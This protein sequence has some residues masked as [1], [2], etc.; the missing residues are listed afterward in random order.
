MKRVLACAFALCFA[1]PAWAATAASEVGGGF[2][3]GLGVIDSDFYALADASVF[4]RS[5][6]LQLGGHLPLRLMLTGDD[7]VRIR[8]QDWDEISDVTRLLRYLDWHP[9]DEVHLR[10]GEP[11]GVTLGHG[12]IVDHFYNATDLDHYKTSMRF[13]WQDP[14][15]GLE[16]FSNDMVRWEILAARA[17]F[18][19]LGGTTSWV[20]DL[21]VALTLAVDRAAPT[22]SSGGLDETNQPIVLRS[23]IS[24]YGVDADIPL[25]RGAQRQVLL[26]TDVVGMHHSPAFAEA[27]GQN[28]GGWHLGVRVQLPAIAPNTDLTVRLE[29]VYMGHGYVPGY[30]DN[31]YEV[32]RFEAQA[33]QNTDQRT[34]VAWA[35]QNNAPF[36]LRGQLD[37]VAERGLRLTVLAALLGDDGLSTQLWLATP[38]YAGMT[39]RGHWGQ[40][41]LQST[42]DM[43]A[44]AR[45]AA[46]A[47]LRYRIG[48]ALSVVMQAG[49]RWEAKDDGYAARREFIG[50]A[51]L[52]WKL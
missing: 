30:F 33:A 43:R 5:E 39:L 19:P 29:G 18:K 8:R 49:T 44:I 42:A 47:E 15:F 40:Q 48:A 22:G 16:V 28:T 6:S 21:Q 9:S 46:L 12:A 25:W 32:E 10:I 38:E 50:A 4:Y 26:Y 7:G 13:S 36:G 51:R 17:S 27:M 41:H 45:T 23:P 31:L 1:A 24:L 37:L 3:L 11:T 35:A 14:R 2:D 52:E 20:R 34:K